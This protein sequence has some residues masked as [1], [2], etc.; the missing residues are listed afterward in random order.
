ME[1]MYGEG[2]Y[3]ET[4][5]NFIS[6]YLTG[7][8]RGVRVLDIGCG[9]GMVKRL[10]PN[11]QVI[12]IDVE[13]AYTGALRGSAENLPFRENRF[14]IVTCFDVIEH[15]PDQEKAIQEIKRV[16]KPGGLAC[17]TVPLY[18]WLWSEHDE[19]VGHI[20]RYYP[21]ELK[22]MLCKNGFIYVHDRLFFSILLPVVILARKV[23]RRMGTGSLVR[24]N[25]FVERTLSLVC[26]IEIMLNLKWPFGL[27]E[28]IQCRKG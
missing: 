21:G 18:P 14:D 8:N 15:V 23:F 26:N 6:K 11:C 27:T 24:G 10:L 5:K 3:F 2:W 22:E 16:L 19:K 4:R 13:P 28:I 1:L 20:R 9:D 17:L 25:N 12:G 7:I